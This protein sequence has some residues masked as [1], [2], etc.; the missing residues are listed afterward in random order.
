VVGEK[1]ERQTR[2]A[3]GQP[4]PLGEQP[5]ALI[6]IFGGVVIPDERLRPPLPAA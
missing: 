5:D 2:I 1:R 3:I 6:E 4:P